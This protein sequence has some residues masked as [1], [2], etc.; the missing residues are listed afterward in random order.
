MEKIEPKILKGFRDF[1]PEQMIIRQKVFDIVKNVFESYGFVPIETPSLEYSEILLSKLGSE[2][3]KLVYRFKDQGS[4][5]VALRYDLTVPLSRFVAQYLNIPKPFKRYQ[6]QPVWRADKPKKGRYR[7]F[8]QCDIDTIG[9]KSSLADA[10]IIAIIYT[11]LRKIGFEKFIIR[12]NSRQILFSIMKNAGVSQ[13]KILSAIQ[14]IDKLDKISFEQVK[15]E[16]IEKNIETQTAEKIFQ[17]IKKAKPDLFLQQVLLL[18]KKLSVPENFLKFDPFLARGLDYYT[19]PIYEAVVEKPKIGS[20]AGGGRY[21]KLIGM[22]AE[23][24]IP[25]CGTTIGIDRIVDAIQELNLWPEISSTNTK[26]LITIIDKSFLDQ[27]IKISQALR[28]E[29]INNEI[30]LD[31]E[32]SLEKQL[33]YANKKEIPF[34]III[35]PEEAIKNQITLRNMKTGEQI[36]V[37]E[38]ELLEKLK[39]IIK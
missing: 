27:C 6:I 21:D 11:V 31:F 4:R 8:T 38:K 33:R 18:V 37:K 29:N 9:S 26:I 20:I 30:Y 24:D 15:Q 28:S 10:E 36:K 1:S 13:D 7:E 35:G 17:L 19:G 3:N 16:L 39:E 5:D 34:V 2:A 32:T 12:I 23:K 22:F 25:A 14:S